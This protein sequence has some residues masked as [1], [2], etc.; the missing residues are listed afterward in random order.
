[1]ENSMVRISVGEP[2]ILTMEW[3]EMSKKLCH[4]CNRVRSKV[5]REHVIEAKDAKTEQLIDLQG[6]IG[7][8]I[9]T[10]SSYLIRTLCP[11]CVNDPTR[12][13]LASFR[14]LPSRKTTLP[15]A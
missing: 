10:Q 5:I 2:Y 13:D 4:W 15:R 1:M 9:I 8:K 7:K 6:D 14:K 12:K 11:E 3:R